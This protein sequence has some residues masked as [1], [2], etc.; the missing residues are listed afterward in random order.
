MWTACSFG[1]IAACGSGNA[2]GEPAGNQTANT[3]TERPAELPAAVRLAIEEDDVAA[4]REY[5]DGGGDPNAITGER[6]APAMQVGAI[7]DD[8]KCMRLLLE[9]GADVNQPDDAGWTPLAFAVAF[10]ANGNVRY[11]LDHG[12]RQSAVTEEGWSALRIAV[13]RGLLDTAELLLESGA[14]PLGSA[15]GADTPLHVGARGASDNS[16]EVTKL[17]L[18]YIETGTDIDVLNDRKT[19]PLMEAL[20]ARKSQ[21][22]RLLLEAGADP[23]VHGDR[24]FPVLWHAARC[25]DAVLFWMLIEAGADPNYHDH[26]NRTPLH[27]AA[28]FGVS[29]VLEELLVGGADPNA[30]D[31]NGDTTRRLPI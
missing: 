29:A 2:G 20:M 23:T 17:L 15:G 16:P 26:E 1:L 4:L 10:H 7:R 21:T 19:T 28:E 13:M 30:Q 3:V 5:L 31:S 22:V 12:A 8:S 25:D 24:D 6:N 11:L 18:R 9:R 14:E 27:A